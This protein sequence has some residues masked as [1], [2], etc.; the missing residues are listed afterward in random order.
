MSQYQDIPYGDNL[1]NIKKCVI[2]IGCTFKI[3]KREQMI[4]VFFETPIALYWLGC[5]VV[6]LSAGLFES[7]LTT[8]GCKNIKIKK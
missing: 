3:R 7:G 4:R 2:G 5:N 6:A 8:H 1:E